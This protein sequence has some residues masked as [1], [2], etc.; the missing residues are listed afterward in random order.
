ME[1]SFKSILLTELAWRN[2]HLSVARFSG[3]VNISTEDGLKTY[4]IVDEQ[5]RD[6]TQVSIPPG[7]P[8][9]LVDQEF[10]PYY[11]VLG[12]DAFITALKS[13]APGLSRKEIKKAMKDAAETK[14]AFDKKQKEAEKAKIEAAS[15]TLDFQ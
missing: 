11:K 7:K 13:V 12:R 4:L 6:L 8:A 2:S 15:P 10:I 5:G 1:T 14:K 9:D 3:G